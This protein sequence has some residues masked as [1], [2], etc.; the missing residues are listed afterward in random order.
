MQ[1]STFYGYGW[2]RVHDLNH[3][4]ICNNYYHTITPK[5]ISR[6]YKT[7]GQR[8]VQTGR[9]CWNSLTRVGLFLH[10]AWMCMQGC[11]FKASLLGDG[12]VRGGNGSKFHQPQQWMNSCWAALG[13]QKS[14]KKKQAY[15]SVSSIYSCI[16][17]P[18]YLSSVTALARA[19]CYH[20]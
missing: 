16:S 9:V 13:H 18:G 4:Q 11:E 15:R 19:R 17:T 7:N 5:S 8:L 3:M 6:C 10:C 1:H 12:S 14:I 2:F 20:L